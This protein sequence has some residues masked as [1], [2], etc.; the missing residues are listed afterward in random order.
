MVKYSVNPRIIYHLFT[1]SEKIPGLL[2]YP[3]HVIRPVLYS[4]AHLLAIA[5]RRDL[6]ARKADI[7]SP[8]GR[9]SI[10]AVI[11]GPVPAGFLSEDVSVRPQ[12][13]R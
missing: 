7:F 11:L 8:Q 13:L 4:V 12:P 3:G 10:L 5:D 9:H 2:E 1:I 6:F